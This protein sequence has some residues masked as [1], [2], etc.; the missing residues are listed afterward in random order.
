MRE[1]C[2]EQV[3][4]QERDMPRAGWR[5]R[6]RHVTSRLVSMRETCHEQVGEQERDMSRAGW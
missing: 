3:G 5:A 4:E 6:E 2:H 1:T